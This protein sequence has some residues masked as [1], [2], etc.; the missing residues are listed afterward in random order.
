V[1]ENGVAEEPT[2]GKDSQGVADRS[3][4][5]AELIAFQTL[6]KGSRLPGIRQ[7]IEQRPHRSRADGWHLLQKLWFRHTL[8][9]AER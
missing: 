1:P 4:V 7:R 3:T 2:V 6:E 8:I 5:C 9:I